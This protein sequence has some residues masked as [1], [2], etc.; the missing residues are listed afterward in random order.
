M[1]NT[2]S[3]VATS[4]KLSLLR[5]KNVF[6]YLIITITWWS[7]EG[8]GARPRYLQG[9]SK[10]PFDLDREGEGEE[11]IQTLCNSQETWLSK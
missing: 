3:W 11:G 5:M 1:S 7:G 9:Q 10:T 2:I 8:A 6:I 4:P